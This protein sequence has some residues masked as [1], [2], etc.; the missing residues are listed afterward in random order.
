MALKGG[1]QGKLDKAT[2]KFTP[3]DFTDAEKQRYTAAGGK[4]PSAKPAGT[5]APTSQATAGKMT[6]GR[7]DAKIDTASVAAA[8]KKA[9]SPAVLNKP[10]PAGSALAKQQDMNKPNALG[11]TQAQLNKLR[12]DAKSSNYGKITIEET[13]GRESVLAEC[14][15]INTIIIDSIIRKMSKSHYIIEDVQSI[16]ASIQ[17]ETDSVEEIDNFAGDVYAAV[18]TSM[19]HEGYSASG[20]L[21]FLSTASDEEILERFGDYDEN[22]IAESTISEEYVNEQVEQLDEIVGAALRVLGAGAKAAKFAGA[23]GLAPLSRIGQGLQGAGRAMSRVAQQGPR[24][25]SVVRSGLSKLKSAAGA[26]LGKLKETGASKVGSA[27]K[28]AAKTLIPGAA[29]FAAG[30]MSAPKAEAPKASQPAAEVPKPAAAPKPAAPKPN[31]N[32][33]T[34]PKTGEKTKF[35]RRLPTM[36][37]L[38]AAQAAL[39]RLLKNWWC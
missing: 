38:R 25:S 22:F 7:P 11:N 32:V 31:P 10:A 26:G 18:A 8:M 34:S 15:L 24:A 3:G 23:Q 16:Y 35:E 1:V 19:L 5:P 33:A 12:A 17:E 4:I 20:I 14:N 13:N 21:G 9:N 39:A 29:G 30:R 2:G 37:E 36:K 27:L 28:G 6:Q